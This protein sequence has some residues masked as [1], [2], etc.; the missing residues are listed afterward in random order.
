MMTMTSSPAAEVARESARAHDGK[1]G[2]QP[3]SESDVDLFD[4]EGAWTPSEGIRYLR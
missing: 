2:T 3:K 1:F 4:S